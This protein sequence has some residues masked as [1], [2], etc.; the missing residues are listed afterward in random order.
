VAIT[1]ATGDSG[2][3]TSYPASSPYVTAVG[4][5]TLTPSAGGGRGWTETA[6]SGGGSGC[7]AVEP[8]P[9]WQH[10]PL[11]S[12]RTEADVAAVGDPQ[13]GL[14]VFGAGTWQVIG[15]T[16]LSTPV[17]AGMY[18]L[19][20]GEGT[21]AGAFPFYRAPSV[22]DIVSGTNSTLPCS[23]A[24]LCAAGAGFDGPTGLG[25]P[26]GPPL[27]APAWQASVSPSS[28][29]FTSQPVGSHSAAQ[30]ATLTN[31]GSS[32]VHVSTVSLGGAN[33]G[34]FALTADG[35][36]GATVPS[37][38][39]CSVGVVFAPDW[40]GARTASLATAPTSRCSATTPMPSPWPPG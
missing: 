7:S 22:H 18:A 1:A 21:G 39:S 36:S 16:S 25:S 38:A 10:D 11:C 27:P 37:G 19:G 34:D 33:P 29:G 3:G 15:G 35:C 40:P 5:T 17:V 13:T 2:F 9:S 20:G 32:A 8:K 6:W 14:D 26:D 30:T 28:L 12:G 23:P 4:G 24:L 31:S